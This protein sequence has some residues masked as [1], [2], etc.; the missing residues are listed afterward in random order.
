LLLA[1]LFNAPSY[2]KAQVVGDIYTYAG[3][4]PGG[5]SGDGG[6]ATSAQ[7]YEPRAIAFDAQQNLYISDIEDYV[8]R[9]VTSGGL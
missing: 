7:L 6:P 3:T 9:K 8:I 5:Y 4:N 1:F 2:L